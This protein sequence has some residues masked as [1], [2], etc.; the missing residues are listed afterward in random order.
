MGMPSP[1]PSF[2]FLADWHTS[3]TGPLDK[4]RVEA[5]TAT[6]KE[7]PDFLVFVGPSHQ[8]RHLHE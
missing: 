8:P 5:G 6:R 7:K 1:I 4:D 2:L 3:K